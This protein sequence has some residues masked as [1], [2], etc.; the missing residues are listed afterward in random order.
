[1]QEII[2]SDSAKFGLMIFIILLVGL[3]LRPKE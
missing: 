3:L 2:L 1:M